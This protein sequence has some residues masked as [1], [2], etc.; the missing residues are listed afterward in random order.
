MYSSPGFPEA[1]RILSGLWRFEV[2]G[3][4]FRV[5]AGLGFGSCAGSL[6]FVQRKKVWRSELG[7]LSSCPGPKS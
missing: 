7:L 1:H 3:L 5:G 4:H 2:K 6:A